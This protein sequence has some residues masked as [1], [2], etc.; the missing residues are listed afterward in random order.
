MSPALQTGWASHITQSV[1]HLP[2]MWETWVQSLGWEVPLEQENGSPLQYSCLENPLDR[3]VWR[4][5]VHG[6]ARQHDLVPSSF[7]SLPLTSPGKYS[8]VALNVPD[9][10]LCCLS[11]CSLSLSYL[12]SAGSSAQ[13]MQGT[14]WVVDTRLS[15]EK[16]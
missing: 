3:G 13:H 15:D 12:F 5:T 11:G 4:A 2:A 7:L 1:K 9:S 16:G 8:P 14:W 10:K 6:I